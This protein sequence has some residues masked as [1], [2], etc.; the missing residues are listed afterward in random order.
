MYLIV[1]FCS[2][3]SIVPKW[4]QNFKNNSSCPH[5]LSN[6]ALTTNVE[7]YAI[8]STFLF[9]FNRTDSKGIRYQCRDE[10][11]YRPCSKS[12]YEIVHSQ[13]KQKM[14]T[15]IDWLAYWRGRYGCSSHSTKVL[16][17][18]KGNKHSSLMRHMRFDIW[19]KFE[20]LHLIYLTDT[21]GGD[22][23]VNL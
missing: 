13:L 7:V 18:N 15:F 17:E 5:Y 4:K 21:H 14:F 22:L 3:N 10:Q 9:Q 11:L 19:T 2:V 6:T 20:Q 16:H 23:F 12:P 1:H 8:L